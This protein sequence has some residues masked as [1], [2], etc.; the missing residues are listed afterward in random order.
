MGLETDWNCC[1]ILSSKNS[2]TKTSDIKAR[3]PR[4]V[5][6]VRNHLQSVDDIPLHV[7]L[8]AESEEQSSLE[9]IKIFQENEKVVGVFGDVFNLQNLPLFLQV[10]L[11]THL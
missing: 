3:L 7:S 1:I 4:G 9:M 5:A 2:Y 10:H 11:A 6:N 8:F